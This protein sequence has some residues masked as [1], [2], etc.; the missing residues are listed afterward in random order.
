MRVITYRSALD[1]RF[2]GS[3]GS[4][5]P[6]ERPSSPRPSSPRPTLVR[7]SQ[8]NGV[9]GWNPGTQ[10][11]QTASMTMDDET[12][13]DALE[14]TIVN[15][16]SSGDSG[17][18]GSRTDRS[19]DML[20]DEKP[21]LTTK[22][23]AIKVPSYVRAASPEPPDRSERIQDTK[24]EPM[25][26]CTSSATSL[27]NLF[28]RGPSERHLRFLQ[29]LWMSR[30]VEWQNYE[31]QN[32]V[33]QNTSQAY[34]GIIRS[35]PPESFHPWRPL[36]TTEPVTLDVPDVPDSPDTPDVPSLISSAPIYPRI[37]N[38]RYLHNLRS[39]LLD[40]ALGDIPLYTISKMLLLHD[41]A[42]CDNENEDPFSDGKAISSES[43]AQ[44]HEYGNEDTLVADSSSTS[45]IALED[46]CHK[47][48]GK[49][50]MKHVF[51]DLDVSWPARWKMLLDLL[52]RADDIQMEDFL[53]EVGL[54][55]MD[56]ESDSIQVKE[57]RSVSRSRSPKF[58]LPDE[59]D[60]D[61]FP[62]ADEHPHSKRISSRVESSPYGDSGNFVP[63][64]RSYDY[65]DL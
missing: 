15:D 23:I 63:F 33:I 26:E 62:A 11:V 6:S 31:R 38:L 13:V 59:D 1:T 41:L 57:E 4:S 35:P 60:D 64:E 43:S 3:S 51:E 21:P 29:G 5:L 42:L 9:R 8:L 40:R 46:T 54:T 10:D 12:W 16:F 17:D 22:T 49:Q 39:V 61:I 34:D 14:R 18:S 36:Q 32:N 30:Q 53:T 56:W 25:E 52:E 19:T 27:A 2:R 28:H 37:G 24:E 45:T 58:F 7:Q 50:V 44:E 65:M 48:K 47:R 20:Q 55:D